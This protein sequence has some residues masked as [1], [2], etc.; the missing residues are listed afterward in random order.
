M[1][2]IEEAVIHFEQMLRND[3]PIHL[4]ALQDKWADGIILEPIRSFEWEEVRDAIKVTPACLII[5]EDEDDE[6]LRDLLYTARLTLIM[7]VT[8]RAKTN[9]TKKLYRYADAVKRMLR[10]A[11]KRSTPGVIVSAIVRHIGYSPTFVDRDQL[12]ARDFQADVRLRLQR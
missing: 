9:T 12:F 11:A 7:I 6:N 3:L 5:G 4:T 2:S 8:D 10:P 1:A